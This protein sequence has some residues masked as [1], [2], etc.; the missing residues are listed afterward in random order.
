MSGKKLKCKVTHSNYDTNLEKCNFANENASNYNESVM[1]QVHHLQSANGWPTFHP[2]CGIPTLQ[3]E[4][5]SDDTT[6]ASSDL[7]DWQLPL[8]KDW[9]KHY[10]GYQAIYST[11]TPWGS[12]SFLLSWLS[13]SEHG[14]PSWQQEAFKERKYTQCPFGSNVRV[15]PLHQRPLSAPHLS[16]THQ[17][18]PAVGLPRPHF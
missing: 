4:F 11:L 12:Y 17:E 1:R 15:E 3:S 5:S 10:F 8:D 18:R 2:P 7:L 6:S 14:V 16:L 9:S 13:V